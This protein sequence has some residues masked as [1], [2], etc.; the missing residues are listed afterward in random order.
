LNSNY[1]VKD[2]A[3]GKFTYKNPYLEAL[4]EEKK[5]NTPE[6][7]KDIL[8]KGGSVQHLKFFS[9][10]EKDVFKTFGEISQKEVLIQA[11]QRQ[12]FIDQS[13]SLNIMVHPKSS[14][15]DVSQLMIFAWEQGVKSLYYQRG[16]NPSQELSRNLLEC[17]SCSG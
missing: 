3:K 8:V 9:D 4:L 5:Q 10:E 2:L 13:Q 6:V 1:F 15:K 12:K 16:T 11:A 14:P 17:Q 7:W